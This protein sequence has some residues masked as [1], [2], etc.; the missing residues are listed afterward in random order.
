LV[1]IKKTVSLTRLLILW[2]EGGGFFQ[3]LISTE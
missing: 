3:A 2:K 1:K